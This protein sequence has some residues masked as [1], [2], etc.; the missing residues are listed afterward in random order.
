MEAKPRPGLFI[1]TGESR[2]SGGRWYY[3][4]LD[5]T[6]EGV[7]VKLFDDAYAKPIELSYS[8]FDSLKIRHGLWC[9]TG[10]YQFDRADDPA[11]TLINMAT[12][13]PQWAGRR[14][15]ELEHLL[16][17]ELGD[18][19]HSASCQCTVCWKRRAYL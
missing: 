2:W 19:G 17:Y 7:L 8:A 15:Y 10:I 1:P 9:R 3:Q 18:T 4:I 16:T 14:I 6:D 12:R 13:D 11:V 5:L